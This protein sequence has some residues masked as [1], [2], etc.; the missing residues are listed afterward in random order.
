MT[1]SSKIQEA[2]RRRQEGKREVC[3]ATTPFGWLYCVQLVPDKTVLVSAKAKSILGE[4]DC[5]WAAGKTY[6]RHQVLRIVT[7]RPTTHYKYMSD[8]VPFSLRTPIE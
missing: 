3:S 4:L 2:E 8:S 7:T 1:Q 5:E 6:M